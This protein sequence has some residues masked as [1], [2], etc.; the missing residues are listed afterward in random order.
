MKKN[1]NTND[2]FV[3]KLE[4]KSK[5]VAKKLEITR[6]QARRILVNWTMLK[7]SEQKELLNIFSEW[8]QSIVRCS[9]CNAFI[10]KNEKC[11]FESNERNWKIICIVSSQ[12]VLNQIESGGFYNGIYFVLDN[13]LDTKK[14]N[15]IGVE[16]LELLINN[17][18]AEELII[19]TSPT[20]NGEMTAVFLTEK[21]AKKVKV[22]RLGYG[23]AY[24]SNLNFVDPNTFKHAF[25][26]QKGKN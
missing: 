11:P 21:F 24:G 16:K 26:K 14:S 6:A 23:I 18:K 2:F 4:Q 13:E 17:M 9:K 20:F 22:T 12:Q 25:F 10:K 8:N 7:E 5:E 19:A 15:N 1:T 3:Q